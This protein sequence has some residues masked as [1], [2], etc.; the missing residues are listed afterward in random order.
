M[1][2]T[3]AEIEKW[4][5][6]QKLPRMSGIVFRAIEDDG[7]L[8]LGAYESRTRTGLY[9]LHPDG[10][11]IVKRQDY[12]WSSG[13]VLT[14]FAWGCGIPMNAR[15][16]KNVKWANKESQEIG[17]RILDQ[18]K[19]AYTGDRD[20]IAR[21]LRHIEE[22][23]N[24][25]QRLNRLYRKERRI[26]ETIDSL[27]E[28]PKDLCEWVHKDVLGE[29]HYFFGKKG[30]DSYYCTACGSTHQK[31]GLKDHG[32]AVCP[33][34]GKRTRVNKR[35]GAV[36]KTVRVQVLQ[37]MEDG[38]NAVARHMEVYTTWNRT[39]IS[40]SYGEQM[41]L[42]L[43]KDTRR[44]CNTWYYHLRSNW[45]GNEFWSDRNRANYRVPREYLYPKTVKE[46]LEGTVYAR[47]GLE[48]AAAKGWELNYNHLMM[49]WRYG[50]TEYL[51]KG[52]FR[53]L[54]R[55]IADVSS[56]GYYAGCICEVGSNVQET[57]MLDGQRVARLRQADGGIGYLRWLRVEENEGEKLSEETIRWLSKNIPWPDEL[58][59]IAGHMSYTRI[60]NYLQSQMQKNHISK[61]DAL[62]K[63]RDY[64]RMA[65]QLKLDV[66]KEAVHRPKDLVAAHAELTET[67]NLNRDKIEKERIEQ[68]YPLIGPTCA[69][70]KPLYE[71]SDGT[72]AV[73]VP[74]GASDIMREGR[75]QHHCVGA[76]N[77]L[78]FDRIAEGESYI[79]FL[80][81]CDALDTPWYTMEVEPGGSVRQLRTLG[82]NE[83]EDRTEAKEALKHWRAEINARL[84]KSKEGKRELENAEGSR[85]KRLQEF[86][87]LRKNKNVIRNGRLAGRLLVEVLEADFKECN[88]T[89]T[90]QAVS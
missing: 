24:E 35:E 37:N 43:P 47:L 15:N 20:N 77:D 38:E 9:I 27:P 84:R 53:R 46:S 11:H 39:G 28:L 21:R 90:V 33:K 72:Y 19:S 5:A 81:K 30:S 41:V 44:S 87:E 17:E 48:V 3:R 89:Q 50:Q 78:Y 73:I 23:Y 58:N 12:P 4:Y 86:E 14:L 10:R 56:H 49:A 13:G 36:Y 71:W 22:K 62:I 45:G 26:Q 1:R 76:A 29:L 82:D 57:L 68:E 32:R 59:F 2:L 70:I 40:Q 52:G 74:S 18:Q 34:T 64:M 69:R 16:G 31:K 61:S 55:E 85:E 80:R 51:I 60:A 54:V 42:F 79:M 75:L 6:G 88:E 66:K 25:T 63:W 67:I 8:I 83:G 7:R 65:H